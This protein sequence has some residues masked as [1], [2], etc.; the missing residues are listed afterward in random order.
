MI[1]Y[2]KKGIIAVS[3]LLAAT[4]VFGFVSCNPNIKAPSAVTVTQ[5]RPLYTLSHYGGRLAL[6][7]RDFA[8]PV[9]IFDVYLDSL[10]TEE[11]EAVKKGITAETDEQAQK[12]IEDYTS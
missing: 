9:E 2:L 12:L 4:I 3:L 5:S 7:K 11:R 10:P 1:D 8:M 6:Y